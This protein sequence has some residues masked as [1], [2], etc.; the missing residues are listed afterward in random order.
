MAVIFETPTAQASLGVLSSFLPAGAKFRFWPEN[1]D[2]ESKRVLVGIIK[3][4]GT[5]AKFICSTRVSALLRAKEITLGDLK[6]LPVAENTTLTG[7]PINVIALTAEDR[8]VVVDPSKLTTSA[9][10]VKPKPTIK[11]LEERIAF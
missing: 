7:E 1:I 10:V 2:D 8:S 3:P 5:E 11:D 4:D 9:P 6:Q